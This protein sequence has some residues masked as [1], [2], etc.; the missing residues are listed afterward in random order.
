MTSY[1]LLG[2]VT[3]QDIFLNGDN[4]IN[5]PLS[6]STLIDILDV[7][8]AQSIACS[9]FDVCAQNINN[10]SMSNPSDYE[11]WASDMNFDD[12]VDVADLSCL[13]YYIQNG[14]V[15]PTENVVSIN[16]S[17][18]IEPNII[19]F[20][21]DSIHR[22]EISIDENIKILKNNLPGNW[23]FI[24]NNNS[25]TAYSPLNIPFN[26]KIEIELNKNIKI[27]SISTYSY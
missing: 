2:N 7:S 17:P 4:N 27:V 10:N 24:E 3:Y 1:G 8:M 23:I 20:N 11:I 5:D 9:Q 14:L 21:A 18:N 13:V 19:Q 12:I 25:I 15:C 26:G 16:I 6:D 22:F